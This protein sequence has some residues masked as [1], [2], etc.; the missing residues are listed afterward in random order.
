MTTK[1]IKG[2]E[3]LAIDHEVLAAIKKNTR[4]DLGGTV[5]VIGIRNAAGQLYRTAK[6]SGLSNFMGVVGAL[7]DLDLVDELEHET[8]M[9]EG[10]DAIFRAPT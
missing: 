5:M 1:L 8:T 10:C 3:P 4:Q 7:Q 2:V 6:V 9:R